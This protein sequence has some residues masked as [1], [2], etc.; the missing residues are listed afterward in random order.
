MDV[1]ELQHPEKV[2]V[3]WVKNLNSIVNKM[4][5]TESSMIGIKPKETTK[6]GIAKL[7][8]LKNI[9]RKTDCMKMVYTDIC[10][11]GRNIL[12]KL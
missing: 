12:D 4:N 7:G 9:Q 2:S 8:N 1:Q 10:S 6:L 3:I 5:I 11:Q